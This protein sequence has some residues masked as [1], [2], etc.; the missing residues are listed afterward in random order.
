MKRIILSLSLIIL[1][2]HA[3]G[4]SMEK[5]LFL[6]AEDRFKSKDYELALDRYDTLIRQYPVT[7]Y[8]PDAQF[9]RAVS[10]YR[11]DKYEDALNL[12][13]KIETR[14]RSTQYLVFVPF[15][16]G[17]VQYHLN[18]HQEAIS[19]FEEYI[20]GPT[21][22]ELE[23]QAYFYKGLSEVVLKKDL[24]AAASFEKLLEITDKPEEEPFALS[25]LLSIYISNKNYNKVLDAYQNLKL[26]A[27]SPEFRERV[28]LY[29]AESYWGLEN[30]TEA[31]LLFKNLQDAT[32]EIAAVAFQRLFLIY[33]MNKDEESRDLILRNAERKLIGLPGILKEFWLRIGIEN[34]KLGNYA[35]SEYYFQ[36]IWDL[37][38]SEQIPGSVPIYLAELL[39]QRKE[40]DK[41]LSVLEEYLV[42]GTDKND[43]V[44]LRAGKIELSRM[45]WNSS[46]AFFK[47]FIDNYTSSSYYSEA[48]YQYAFSLYRQGD[49]SA[50]F[51]EIQRLF[52]GGLIG[53]Y[54]SE[55]LRLKSV[56]ERVMDLHEEAIQTLHEYIPLNTSDIDAHIDLAELLFIEKQYSKV[57][58]ESDILFSNFPG[59]ESKNPR[60]YMLINYM[61]GLS[62]IAKKDYTQAIDSLSVFFS[63]TT[64]FEDLDSIYPY[65]YF[66]DGWA[67]YRLSD[68]SGAVE[69]F[70]LLLESYPGHELSARSAYLAGWCSYNNAQFEEAGSYL[71]ILST[72]DKDSPLRIKGA[73][74]TG[75][76]LANLEDFESASLEFRNIFMEFPASSFADDAMFEHANVLTS[77]GLIDEAVT[78]Y[79]LLFQNFPESPLI[80]EAMYKRGELLLNKNRPIEAIDAFYEYRSNFPRG[81]LLDAALYWGG[82]ASEK[83]GETFGAVML[84][85][86]LIKEKRQSPFRGDAMGRTAAI[87]SDTGDFNASLALY[88]ELIA[89]YPEEASVL[90]ARRKAD[91]IRY[92]ILGL[93]KKEAEL[94]VIIGREGGAKSQ[95]GRD[96]ML[97]LSRLYL[98]ES[99]AS[100]EFNQKL[101]LPM[102]KEIIGMAKTDPYSAAHAQYLLAEYYARVED[103]VQAANM[104]LEAAAA[105][106]SDEDLV[107]QALF[108]G[109]EMMKLEG[110]LKEAQELLDELEENFPD[111]EWTREAQ[112]LLGGVQ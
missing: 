66:Y 27:I 85:E 91:E 86:R 56:V 10:L 84:W 88:T 90:E 24:D 50:S 55:L 32:P 38:D 13:K 79:F 89:S 12:F 71:S 59:F 47:S 60:D 37:R 19:A 7:S 93:S 94:S 49:Y 68:Y 103:Y 16:K 40:I 53:S 101:A 57:I 21:T 5:E 42:F 41:A 46:A 109:V 11:L 87:Y 43:Q 100:Q 23:Q 44:I 69:S 1:S 111:S 22:K 58:S 20:K 6:E 80:E 83:A 92:L 76:S 36:R 98:F 17:I 110:M 70:S 33:Q 63:E 72:L 31:E 28:V 107:E 112:R 97:E 64:S 54:S 65:S 62:L 8:L 106:P 26:E 82:V 34:F 61:R 104:F 96:A 75:K 30:Y 48:A 14:Y 74:L 4:Q 81:K 25:Q 108:R 3:F 105:Y 67:K 18:L 77:M 51:N 95:P 102:L 15:W 73:F 99:G 29:A 9:K 2:V 35:L 39:L 45:N 52:R 78:E